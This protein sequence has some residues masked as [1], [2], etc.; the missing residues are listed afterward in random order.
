MLETADQ[1]ASVERAMVNVSGQKSFIRTGKEKT[2][3]FSSSVG[4]EWQIDQKEYLW[5]SEHK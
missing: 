3:I 1:P 5:L 4:G 2:L